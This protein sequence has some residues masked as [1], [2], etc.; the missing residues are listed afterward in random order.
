MANTRRDITPVRPGQ[1]W[2]DMDPRSRGR[3]IRVDFV[4]GDYAYVTGSNGRK[5]R[6]KISRM[7]PGSNGYKLINNP[8]PQ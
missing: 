6:I 2:A 5:T 4:V 8:E 1:E 3:T 7:R